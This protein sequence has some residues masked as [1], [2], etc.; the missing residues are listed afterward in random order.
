MHA[1]SHRRMNGL[2]IQIEHNDV[3]Q[4]DRHFGVGRLHDDAGVKI[5]DL[6]QNR[7]N[8]IIISG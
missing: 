2:T 7:E 6:Q 4:F 1:R 5:L 3:L 8:L